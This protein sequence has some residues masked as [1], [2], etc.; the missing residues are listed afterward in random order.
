MVLFVLRSSCVF[1]DTGCYWLTR[2][3]VHSWDKPA[4]S[5]I[6]HET[7]ELYL[8]P[9]SPLT[10]SPNVV[11]VIKK[12]PINYLD[13]KWQPRFYPCDHWPRSVHLTA[14]FILWNVILQQSYSFAKP[15]K[16]W[17]TRIYCFSAYTAEESGIASM[18]V[19]DW[20]HN[21]SV[22]KMLSFTGLII[23]N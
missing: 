14:C 19:H 21:L 11:I 15:Q 13:L 9:V 23:N 20:L 4:D 17:K 22:S 3:Y 1:R 18:T 12:S 5:K 8:N 7:T 10:S 16:F 2:T 6:Q